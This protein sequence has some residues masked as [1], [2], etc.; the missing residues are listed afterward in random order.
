[1]VFKPPFKN[2]DYLTTRH[3]LNIQIPD[4]SGIQMVTVWFKLVFHTQQSRQLNYHLNPGH[5]GFRVLDF[6]G[7]QLIIVPGFHQLEPWELKSLLN[8]RTGSPHHSAHYHLC[9][10]L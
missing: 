5:S 9:D 1:M 3:V 7:N 10:V 2:L 6:P 4:L 8:F